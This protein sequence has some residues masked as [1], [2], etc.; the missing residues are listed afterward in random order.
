MSNRDVVQSK[1][2]FLRSLGIIPGL[3]ALSGLTLLSGCGLAVT[4]RQRVKKAVRMFFSDPRQATEI[5]QLYINSSGFDSQLDELLDDLATRIELRWRHSSADAQFLLVKQI[6][7]DF[8]R[9]NIANFYGWMLS[10]TE[11]RIYAVRTMV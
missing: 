10:P 2:L 1:R 11:L 4:R 3:F 9:G 6:R 8:A 7:N 5:G